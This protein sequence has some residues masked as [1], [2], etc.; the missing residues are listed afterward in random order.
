MTVSGAGAVPVRVEEADLLATT[1]ALIDREGLTVA[2]DDPVPELEPVVVIVLDCEFEGEDDVELLGVNGLVAV[3]L[4][5]TEA[6]AETTDVPDIL[7]VPVPT[8]V[9]EL[10]TVNVVEK[11]FDGVE[12]TVK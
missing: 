9:C 10:S 8:Y 4:C 11:V 3:P 2:E 12:V 1:V 6:Q 7:G 5:E